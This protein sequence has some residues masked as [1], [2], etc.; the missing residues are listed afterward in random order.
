VKTASSAK[1]LVFNTKGD[2]LVLY[3]SETH[4]WSPHAPDLPGGI[5]N[6]H[7]SFEDGIVR[8]LQE[9][10]GLIVDPDKLEKLYEAEALEPHG[11]TMHRVIFGVHLPDEHPNVVLSWEHEKFEWRKLEDIKDIEASNQKGIDAILASRR[12]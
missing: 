1:I 11:I 12:S 9:E 4:P 8:E 2:V 6:S 3:R 7:E 10:T 5:V